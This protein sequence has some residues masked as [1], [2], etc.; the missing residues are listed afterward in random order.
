MN[1]FD[2]LYGV[3]FQPAE[4]FGEIAKKK[5][6]WQSIIVLILTGFLPAI[7]QK[8]PAMRF[9]SDPYMPDFSKMVPMF[10]TMAVF[11]TIFI[12][13]ITHFVTT[14]VYHLLAELFD[15]KMFVKYETEPT[16]KEIVEEDSEIALEVKG[17]EENEVIGT[18]KGLYSA[19]AFATLPMLFTVPFN[20]IFRFTSLNIGWLFTIIFGIWVLVLKII[21]I[22]ENYKVNGGNAAL[23]Y[24]LPY[25]VGIILFVILMIFIGATMAS[26]F[27]T[28]L[29]DMPMQY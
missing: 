29:K 2:R 20:L 14:S 3:L 4:T 19:L 26:I 25:I 6:I 9:P 27:S 22:K 18:G 21:A 8:V 13:P 10:L 5:P 11:A 24:F 15:G 1:F 16:L 23:I 7:T 17:Q 28:F 12:R